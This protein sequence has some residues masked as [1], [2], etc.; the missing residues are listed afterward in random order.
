[1]REDLGV[2]ALG[3]EGSLEAPGDLAWEL[4][5]IVVMSQVPGVEDKLLFNIDDGHVR[6]GDLPTPSSSLGSLEDEVSL[7][8][9]QALASL[10]ALRAQ[11]VVDGEVVLDDVKIEGC[12]LVQQ[13]DCE[14][15]ELAL[16]DGRL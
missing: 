7:L 4:F 8:A 13:L 6:F 1:M 9:V 2:G 11:V 15:L 10:L 12:S 5:K 3:E 14:L 16:A